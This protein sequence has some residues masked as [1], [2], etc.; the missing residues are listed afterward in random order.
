MLDMRPSCEHCDTPLPAR[1]LDARICTFECTFCADCTDALLGGICPNCY[2]E[3]IPRPTRPASDGE[4]EAGDDAG[5]GG[6]ARFHSPVD[7][8]RHAASL[9]TR[10]PGPDHAG[11]TL[12]RYADCWFRNDL[13]GLVA[14]YSEDFTLH[15]SGGSRFAGT[16]HGR[17]AALTAMAE[18]SS[19]AARE[20]RSIDDVL[21]ADRGGAL[22][23]TER[24]SRDGE[25]VE[26]ERLFRYRVDAGLLAE[27]WLY[28]TDQSVIDH[29]WR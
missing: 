2:G 19:V 17:H 12:R 20:L 27:C 22:A 6:G 8:G 10:A 21:I 24:L 28:E 4:R 23:V 7:L 16:H 13:S 18:V 26:V 1:S 9:L 25:T 15:Y 14:C 11:V 29:F 5:T 3:L